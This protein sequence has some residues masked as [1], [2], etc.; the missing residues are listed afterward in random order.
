MKW[1][2]KQIDAFDRTEQVDA[3]N[4]ILGFL[5]R[6]EE[7]KEKVH[8]ANQQIDKFNQKVEQMRRGISIKK[9]LI[10]AIVAM[11]AASFVV[12]FNAASILVVILLVTY[13]IIDKVRFSK[14]RNEKASQ[15]YNENFPALLQQKTRAEAE[16]NTLCQ[17]DDA[18]NARLLLPDDYLSSDRVQILMNLLRQRRARSI[19]EAM[20]LYENIEHQKRLENIEQEKLKAAQEA[21]KA[22]K[23]AA[24]AAQNTEK[25]TRQMAEKQ[26]KQARQPQQIIYTSPQT[27]TASSAKKSK[28]LKPCPVCKMEISRKAAVCPYCHE[29]LTTWGHAFWSAF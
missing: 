16:Y 27:S 7:K 23:K 8:I 15:F 28:D 10:I 24:I 12:G 3:L 22:Q 9:L 17:S 20:M 1:T 19:S 29:D 18:Y 13:I 4:A 26:K 2:E 25:L 14:N 6:L 11:V 21:A 5:K